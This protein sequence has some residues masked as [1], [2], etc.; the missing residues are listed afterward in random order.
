MSSTYPK[1]EFDLAADDMPVGMHRPEPS[2]WRHVMPFLV[3]LVAVPVLA[4]SLSQLLTGSVTQ[5]Q[6]S[7]SNT[8]NAPQSAQ[9]VQSAPQS[10]QVAQS[11]PQS[12]PAAQSE[13][14][15]SDAHSQASQVN[16]NVRIDVLNGTGQQGLAA[17]KAAQ[18]NEAG[19]NGTNAANAA[20][21][22]TAA[23]TVYYGDAQVEA[24]ARAVAEKLGISNVALN[25]EDIG[26]ADIVVVLK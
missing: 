1:D 21:W 16:Y 25:A 20:G 4:W 7:A 10:D 5:G 19:F 17:E 14:P 6:S 26:E 8:V 13:V 23:S 12:E 24:T 11:A 15:Q 3:I 2:R 18:L 22:T 9:S